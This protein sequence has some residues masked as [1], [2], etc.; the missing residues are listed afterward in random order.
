METGSTRSLPPERVP[1]IGERERELASTPEGRALLELGQSEDGKRFLQMAESL[2]GR[3]LLANAQTPAGKDLLRRERDRIEEGREASEKAMR[4]MMYCG[5]GIAVTATGFLQT[6]LWFFH[7]E[8]SWLLWAL[9]AL[10]DFLSGVTAGLLACLT[11][12]SLT[13]DKSA[14]V[15]DRIA[16]TLESSQKAVGQAGSLIGSLALKVWAFFKRRKMVG[17]SI[18]FYSILANILTH[19][20]IVDSKPSP[21]DW[22]RDQDLLPPFLVGMIA[23]LISAVIVVAFVKTVVDASREAAPAVPMTRGEEKSR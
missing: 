23:T 16:D 11:A 7:K 14:T 22:V 19:I 20:P 17:L 12:I 18:L 10:N 9:S 8:L 15:A 4:R 6:V 13:S 21:P 2:A 5:M 3:A 1:E